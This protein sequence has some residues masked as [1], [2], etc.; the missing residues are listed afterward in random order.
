MPV[1]LSH[2]PREFVIRATRVFV[3]TAEISVAVAPF[4]NVTLVFSN[5]F[6]CSTHRKPP[7]YRYE[8]PPENAQQLPGMLAHHPGTPYG[9]SKIIY[10]ASAPRRPHLLVVSPG[11]G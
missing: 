2:L 8:I 6:T 7:R 9:N 3:A 5:I 1:D 11:T 4:E 10:G